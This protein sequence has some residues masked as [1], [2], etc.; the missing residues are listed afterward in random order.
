[1]NSEIYNLLA[2]YCFEQFIREY[3]LKRY[4]VHC[5]SLHDLEQA[6]NDYMGASNF[7]ELYEVLA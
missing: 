1:M 2:N 7:E 3:I 4:G 6:I 5:R